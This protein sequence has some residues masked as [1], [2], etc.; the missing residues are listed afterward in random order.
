MPSLFFLFMVT[1]MNQ[2]YTIIEDAEQECRKGDFTNAKAKYQEAIEVLGPQNENLSQNK[3]SSDV[4]QAIDLLKQDITAKIQELELLIEK[5]SSEENNIGMVNNNMLIGSVILNN[6]S[7]INGI[8]NARNWDNPAYQD[9]LSPINDPLL[10]S[11]LN[12][13]QFNLNNDI[14]L[15][16][17]GG[18]N[19]KNSEMK[20]NLRLEQFKKELVLYEQKKFKEYGMKI[21]EIT[22]ENKKLANEIGRLRERWDSLV[23]SA[24]QRRDKQKNQTNKV[25]SFQD[26]KY[27]LLTQLE[28]VIAALLLRMPLTWRHRA[29][30]SNPPELNFALRLLE[31]CQ[32]KIR[33]KRG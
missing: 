1:N 20:I 25:I 24:K 11:I 17:E 29:H 5:Q 14:Q 18:K 15:K 12:R 32:I 7:P 31:D 27:R 21:D 33:S 28:Y 13:L 22:K 19:S 26:T 4:T 10:M 6:K 9:T 30:I 16:T 2:V 8:N 23:E 3:L